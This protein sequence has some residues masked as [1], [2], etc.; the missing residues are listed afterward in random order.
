ML[1]WLRRAI[2]V[3][4]KRERLK[5]AML[6]RHRRDLRKRLKAILQLE[7]QQADGQRLRQ[8]Y[9]KCKEGLLVFVTDREVPFHEQRLGAGAQAERDIPQG[10]DRDPFRA[11]GSVRLT[12]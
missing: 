12:V 1:A 7:P 2:K 6:Q 11:R 5:D 9:A 10:D 8:R 4:R 3:G